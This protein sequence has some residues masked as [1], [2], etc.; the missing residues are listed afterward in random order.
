MK[1]FLKVLA[2]AIAVMVGQGAAAQGMNIQFDKM[3]VGTKAYFE[4]S[5]GEEWVYVY[6][7]K[8]QGKYY[9]EKFLSHSK[10]SGRPE[11]KLYFDKQGRQV[12][13]QAFN[14]SSVQYRVAYRPYNCFTSAKADCTHS[15]GLT[16]IGLVGSGRTH[17][18]IVE[19]KKTSNGYSVQWRRKNEPL[20]G[21]K[22]SVTLGK[23][24]F[25]ALEQGR[26]SK[27]YTIKLVRVETP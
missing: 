18:L 11:E 10:T 21:G 16:T 1:H 23:Y 27:P 25:F 15:S 26:P 19:T 13:F 14:D 22:Y 12:A 2:A 9:V 6:K 4:A 24:N 20:K 17:K 7:G 3:P 8:K 5:W